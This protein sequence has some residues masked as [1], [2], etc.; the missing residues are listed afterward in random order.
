[1]KKKFY[2]IFKLVEKYKIIIHTSLGQNVFFF[3]KYLILTVNLLQFKR[4]IFKKQYYYFKRNI[5][6]IR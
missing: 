2:A 3:S 1:M 5:C 4:Q 6:L